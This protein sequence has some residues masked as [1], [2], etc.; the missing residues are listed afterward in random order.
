MISALF[1]VT[2]FSQ[3]TSH[4]MQSVYLFVVCHQINCSQEFLHSTHYS[5]YMYHHCSVS[6][7]SI[8]MCVFGVSGIPRTPPSVVCVCIGSW[9]DSFAIQL[10][11]HNLPVWVEC[12]ENNPHS[13]PGS[14]SCI[15]LFHRLCVCVMISITYDSPYWSM[16][17]ILWCH[18]TPHIT[19]IMLIH[20]S[21]VN[22]SSKGPVLTCW[23]K[24]LLNIACVSMR[25]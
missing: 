9:L 10:G 18:S 2:L 8:C 24:V 14:V 7:C 12:C 5:I 15:R 19:A 20:E 25:R 6:D 16:C 23:D 3:Q 4:T 1:L 21:T 22:Y 13:S 11:D 17:C